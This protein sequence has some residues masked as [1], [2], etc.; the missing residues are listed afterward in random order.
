[1]IEADD[2]GRSKDTDPR[3]RRSGWWPIVRAG[4]Q[5]AAITSAGRNEGLCLAAQA[6]IVGGDLAV[7][8]YRNVR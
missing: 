8:L 6:L 5:L 7:L 1:V 3:R 2:D 4:I